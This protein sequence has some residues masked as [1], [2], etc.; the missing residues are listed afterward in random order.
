M[1]FYWSADEQVHEMACLEGQVPAKNKRC[2]FGAPLAL[3]GS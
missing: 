2:G 3:F 1:E